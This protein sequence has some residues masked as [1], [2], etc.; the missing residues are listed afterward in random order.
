VEETRETL[1]NKDQQAS[2]LAELI[3]TPLFKDMLNNCLSDIDPERGASTARTIIWEDPQL[4]LSIVASLPLIVNWII[5]FLGEVGNQA[6]G[7][8]PPQLIKS[9][10]SNIW[11]D[12]DRQAF[13]DCLNSY[14]GLIRGA[15]KE[16][17]DLEKALIE[18][19]K[20]P[21][22]AAA[23]RGINSAVR[24]INKIHREDPLFM[25]DLISAAVSGI[26]GKELAEASTGIV[27]AA[28][29]QKPRLISWVWHLITG[30]IKSRFER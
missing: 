18:A 3:R 5:T 7:K 20:G 9:F 12:I 19:M 8:F 11:Q 27:N 26:D 25:K 6:A 30:R 21:A 14:A 2:V 16:S 22:A 17:P 24:Y 23:G 1:N 15:L 28:L 10:A 4:I 29:D 13:K